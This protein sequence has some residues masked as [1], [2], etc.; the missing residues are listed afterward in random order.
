M[1]DQ[2]KDLGYL[3][4]DR[5]IVPDELCD[6]M[7]EGVEELLQGKF[8]T[9]YKPI[10]YSWKSGEGLD[11]LCEMN[12]PHICSS[13]IREIIN[14]QEMI[15]FI[16]MATGVVSMKLVTSQLF[17]KP[18]GGNIRQENNFINFH[19]DGT[20]AKDN[21]DKANIFSCWVPLCDMSPENG[22]MRYIARSH[23]VGPGKDDIAY[24]EIG[25]HNELFEGLDCFEEYVSIPRGYLSVHH[26]DLYHGSGGNLSDKPR[27][28]VVLHI[29]ESDYIISDSD[30]IFTPIHNNEMYCPVLR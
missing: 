26:G 11:K 2:Y 23:R 17:Y 21:L 15:D 20:Y 4:S 28:A 6:L 5:Q 19:Q 22:T 16:S 1:H 29:I 25:Q 14:C 27:V 18:A 12:G 3:M 30:T 7:L 13:K 9:G 24:T 10:E 8:D